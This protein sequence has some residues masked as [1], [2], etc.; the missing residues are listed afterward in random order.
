MKT[1]IVRV[2]EMLIDER[3]GKRTDVMSCHGRGCRVPFVDFHNG[4]VYSSAAIARAVVLLVQVHCVVRIATHSRPC[5]NVS[6]RLETLP[7]NG[8]EHAGKSECAPKRVLHTVHTQ[9]R[10]LDDPLNHTLLLEIRKRHTSNRSVDLQ[11]I[12][13]HGDCDEAV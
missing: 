7:R 13:K 4:K 5:F 2:M 11:T 9:R 6:L 8:A 3:Y 1:P 10:V 12:D